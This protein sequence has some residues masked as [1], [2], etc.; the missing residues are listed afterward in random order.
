M[1]VTVWNVV[2]GVGVIVFAAGIAGV[3][4]I[5]AFSI[6]NEKWILPSLISIILGMILAGIGDLPHPSPK[7]DPDRGIRVEGGWR[8]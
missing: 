2:W 7:N 4:A 6:L 5:D 3:V 1:K 8:P